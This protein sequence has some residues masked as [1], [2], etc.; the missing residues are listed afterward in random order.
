[1]NQEFNLVG[2]VR[3]FIKWKNHILALTVTSG[4]VAALFSFFVMDEYFY[5]WSTFYPTNQFLSD[6]SMIFNTE[7]TGNQVNYFGD[8]ND[9]NRIL[10]IANSAPLIEY[11]IDSFKLGDHY[12]IDKS[13]PYWHTKVTKKFNKNYSAIKTERDAVEVSI[14]DTDPKLACNIVNA[15]VEKI[16]ILNRQQVNESKQRLYDLLAMQ[17]A[18]QQVKVNGFVDT[19]A[20]LASVY[21]IRVASATGSTIVVDGNDFKAVQQYKALLEKQDNAIK[22]L[23]NRS[24]IKEQMEV[25]LRSNTSS[26]FTVEKAFAADRKSKPVRSLIVAVTMIISMFVALLGV[27]FIEQVREIKEQL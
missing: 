2:V 11:I 7:S 25:S 26:I 19:L 18:E 10:S 14:Y 1:M 20:Q 16:D 13:D 12:K 5:S 15:V 23:N 8:K 17:I 27:L 3:T 22:E 21:K 9:V 4:V 24:N 6:R